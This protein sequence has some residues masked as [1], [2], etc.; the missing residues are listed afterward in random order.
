[1]HR[2][3]ALLHGELRL[4]GSALG[5]RG[6]LIADGEPDF[7]SALSGDFSH[8]EGRAT[9][10]GLAAANIGKPLPGTKTGAD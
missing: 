6:R 10:P 7:P 2:L 1:M 4:I 8:G 5:F 9:D 3:T